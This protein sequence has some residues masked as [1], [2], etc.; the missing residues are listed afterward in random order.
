M[1]WH[2]IACILLFSSCRTNEKRI[3]PD[4]AFS[5]YI[6]AFTAGH[7]SARSPIMV[8]VAEDQRWLD[9]TDNAIQAL[10]DLEPSVKGRVI[11][12]E[13]NTFIFQP[14]ERLEQDRTYTVTFHLGRAIDVKDELKEFKFQ[15]STYAQGIDANVTELR[16]ISTTD[17]TWQRLHVA[18]YTSD[19][20]TGQPLEDCFTATQ[21]DRTLK[22]H[23]EHD[24]NGR[25]HRFTVDSIHRGEEA[26]MVTI[27]W[28]GEK[29]GAKDNKA[30]L[31]QEIPSTNTL[32]LISSHTVTD[33]EQQAILQFSDPLDPGQDLI[34]LVGIGGENDVRIAIDGNRIN[35][36]PTA[37]LSGDRQAFVS[38]GLKNVNG[39]TL[40][41]DIT[42]DLRFEDLK[43]AVRMV[44]SGTILPSSDGL[45]MPF[46][47]VN[48]SAVEV[49]IVK[50]HE[51]NVSQF[52]QVNALGGERELVRVGRLITR[53]TIPLKTSDNPD[54]GRWNRYFLDLEDLFKSEPGAIYRVELSF[55]R[56]HSTYPCEGKDVQALQR[57]RTW[58]E[59]QAEYDQQQDG[60][61]YYEDHYYDE[62]FDWREQEDPCTS[63]YYANKKVSRNLLA[64][65]LGLIAK[66][67][68]DGSLLIAASDLLSASPV[69]GVKLDVLDMQRKSMAQVVTDREGLVTL[70][71][72]KHKPFLI[73]ASKGDQR[74]YL[75]LDDGASLSLSEMDVQGEAIDRGLKGFIYGERGVWRPGDSLYL[76]F[77]LQDAQNKLPE[78]HPVVLE[79]TDPRG[80]LD[81]KH[82]RTTS[83]NGTYSF[84]MATSPDAPTGMWG[85]Q[86]TV[87][88]TS[89]HKGIRIETVKPNRL[90]VMLDLPEK[91]TANSVKNVKLRST[92]L[93]GAPARDLNTRVTVTM[94][95]SQPQFKGYEKYQF[96]DIR[97]HVPGEEQ[98]AFEG[99]LNA[100]GEATFQLGLQLGNTAPAAVN[101]NIVTRVF[102]AGGDA[103]MDRVSVPYYPYSS[104]SAILAADPN[105]AW[106][107]YITD[108]TYNFKVANVD[109]EGRP[110]ANGSLTA[111]IYKLT[112]NWWWDGGMDGPAN[113][114]SSPSVELKQEFQL[115]TDAKGHA[116]MKFRIDRPEWGSFAVRVT[117]NSSGHSSGI[118]VHLDWPGWE[119]RAQRGTAEQ[120]A[121]LTFNS[122]KE[123]YNVGE[124][125]TLIIPS[126][127]T[128]RALV[129]LE[130]GS[131]VLDAV[132]IELKEKETRYTFP[133]TGDMAPNI[134]AHVTLV[135]PHAK[136]L[137]DLPIRLYGVI[138]ILVEDAA[139]RL[140]PKITAPKEIRTDVPFD[141]EVSEASGE[142]MTYTLAIV[143][144]G[145]LDLTRFKTPD[146]WNHFYAREALGVRTWDLYDDVIGA[147]ARQL[148]RLLAL[149]GSDEV[150]PG[151]AARANRFKPVVKFV[152]PFTVQRGKKAKHNFTISNYVGSVRVMVV[153]SDG[154]KAYGNAEQTVPVRKPL[155]VL[156][157]M[158]R[159]L[160]PGE[161]ADLPVTV[162]AMDSKLQDV[163]VKIEPNSLLVPEGQAQKTITFNSTGDQVVTFKVKVKDA[164][165]VAKM[166][167]TAEGSGE[168][169]TERIELQ[170]RQ[171]N[172]PITDVVERVIDAGKSW[173]YAATPIGVTGTNSAYVE[174]SSIPP[175][176][177]GRR[178]QYLLGYPHGCLEQ[179][180][181]K[182]FPQLYVSKV[183]EMPEKSAALARSN[184]EA[185]LRKMVQFQRHDGGF[186][187][188]PGGD[189]YDT[190]TSIYA[191]HFIVE[192]DR[193]GH[194]IPGNI[195][196]TWLNFQRRMARE[197]DP[198]SEREYW[199]RNQAQL[200]QAYRLYVLALAK[201][202]EVGAMNRLREQKD[203]DLQARW[204]LAAAYA[205]IGRIDAAREL[206]NGLGTDVSPYR[207]HAF[208]YGSDLRDEALITD[209]LIAMG[210]META[211]LVVQRI[212][213][214][215]SSEDWYSTQST[216]FGLLAVARFAEKSDLGKG[217]SYV[218]S[219]DGK[220]GERFS[221][222]AISRADLPKPDGSTN[223]TLENKGRNIL[224]ARVVRT[225]TPLAGNEPALAN[226]MQI[227]VTYHRMD[228]TPIDPGSIDQGTDLMAVVQLH[229][230][231][232]G[233]NYYQMA[234]TQVFP[235]GWEIRNARLEGT[236]H[237]RN[238]SGYTYRDIRDDRVM[239]YFD[240]HR[241]QTLTYHVL[242]N[243]AYT[244]RY[245]LPGAHCE[246]MY[247][248]TV[249]ARNKGRW[250]E[251]VPAGTAKVAVK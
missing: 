139:T 128:G 224:Y 201:S 104:Y 178:L 163:L 225:G 236:E 82:V 143:D 71:N 61:Y 84:R 70:P 208:T 18:V 69:S 210:D 195:K 1:L 232:I 15:V 234:L 63:S 57:E 89:F 164:V 119:G 113:Y 194:A 44:G 81:Q 3:E 174:I 35:L 188:W 134:Y 209:A 37:R 115:T 14:H 243:A 154:E 92:W 165:G 156:A 138:P 94:S 122:D 231:G 40:G 206:I 212:S 76:T 155:M 26:S 249:S 238:E 141:V 133:I 207:E 251:V 162:F 189:Y 56:S 102:E 100:Q 73:I 140:A 171:P 118:Q 60:Y 66:R 144:E 172:L 149:G 250:V 99:K 77:I 32:A 88:G 219:I 180:T 38:A 33:G 112:N 173:T 142:A 74:G 202:N 11:F 123:K 68:N 200:T 19:D 124:S 127:G 109:A 166:K 152:G 244:G 85:A 157:T 17:V 31:D 6:P 48:L 129:S 203:L 242:L 20:A 168:S 227:D 196:N 49:R 148:H 21:N 114:I 24:V 160:A 111:R 146:P 110:I 150:R 197:W 145:L 16:S 239:T 27:S 177:M 136:T 158:P 216:A 214:M 117:D 75:K 79:F 223:F 147:V 229:H 186:N 7:I 54:P 218:L 78:D 247:D 87:G 86:I 91:L 175:V 83:V 233:D 137:N 151:D 80:R 58:E 96:N 41:R 132:W 220:G 34:G 192:A 181:S 55:N 191:G 169:A 237:A 222:K 62:E 9:T 22:L 107:S 52:L 125:A 8:R 204:T 12:Q 179:T 98:V 121:M 95:P 199:S 246:A 45:T 13:G 97:N 217:M 23:W 2:I 193:L 59:E 241:G 170:V 5:P 53:R 46:E 39:R 226:R 10:F 240:L 185:A 205:H 36:Y 228:G 64:S 230:P 120:P 4:A 29:I 72:T 47:A 245:Y 248:N 126:S 235:S 101:T 30:S 161:T 153:A 130:N 28:N 184:V 105:S 183:M 108:T 116:I 167:V 190:W 106:G 198:N 182:A 43:P 159:V 25:N 50:I 187:Y 42:V 215:L 176:D 131:R 221:E 135:Q 93:H 90:K 213:E 211:A 67:G 65:D 103:S 51:N